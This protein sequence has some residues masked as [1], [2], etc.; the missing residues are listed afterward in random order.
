METFGGWKETDTSYLQSLKNHTSRLPSLKLLNALPHVPEHPARIKV[1][2][3]DDNNRISELDIRNLKHLEAY[4]TTPPPPPSSSTEKYKPT[5]R[6]YL[7]EDISLPYVSL[8]GSHFHIDPRFFTSYLK[9]DP[10][11]TQ[12]FLQNYHTMRRLPSLRPRDQYETFVYHEI[13]TFDGPAPRREEYEILTKDNVRRLVT[14]VDHHNGAFT[15][16]V[17]RNLGVWWKE[18]GGE[19]GEGIWNVILLLDPPMSSHLIIK[20]WTS[21]TWT[22]ITCP[23]SSY[24][25]GPLDE[26]PWP[27]YSPTSPPTNPPQPPPS[28]LKTLTSHLLSQPPPLSP[29]LIPHPLLS[30]H[31]TLLLEYLIGV[32]SDLEKGLLKFEQMDAHP[33]AEHITAE[34]TTLRCLLSDVN[35]WRRRLYFYL[36]QMLWNVESA[37]AWGNVPV[38][39][40]DHPRGHGEKVVNNAAQAP[41]TPLTDLHHIQTHLLLLQSRIQSLLPVVMGAFSLL[42]AQHSV[43]K[44]DLTIRL[45]GIALVFVPLS[46]TASLLSMSDDFTPG[47]GKFWVFWVVS[48]PLIVGLFWWGFWVQIGRVRRGWRWRGRGRE[49]VEFGGKIE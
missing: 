31:W 26:S 43:L 34:V 38:G 8:I 33:R 11:R 1:L 7:I 44:A 3:Y 14:T 9:F 39:R 28:I 23:N 6:F 42:E 27:P 35:S 19:G 16:L 40:H 30:S 24:L 37:V 45:S 22:P 2:E 13:R 20:P 25:D 10:D 18:R 4:L 21:N 5:T 46:F 49:E 32:V 15:G 12:N 36:E 17:R 29:P 48:A 41:P 47:K